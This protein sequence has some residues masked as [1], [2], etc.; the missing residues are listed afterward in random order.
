MYFNPH[1][2]ESGDVYY[3]YNFQFIFEF[4][5]TPLRE[6]WLN[7]YALHKYAFIF[8]STPL[9]EWWPEEKFSLKSCVDFNP[10]HYESGDKIRLV[11]IR[12]VNQFQS[13]PLREW[14]RKNFSCMYFYLLFQSTPLRE[15]WHFRPSSKQSADDISIH[16]TTRVVTCRKWTYA[17]Y[18]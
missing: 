5:S 3:P 6:W 18:K 1:H 9:R 13:T 14:W 4:Q 15:W 2:Y 12:L 17:W 7:A 16:T 10:H 8:Q 11:K